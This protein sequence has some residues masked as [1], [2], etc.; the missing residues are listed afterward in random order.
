MGWVVLAVVGIVIFCVA[1]VVHKA[2]HCPKCKSRKFRYFGS[3]NYLCLNCGQ[4][5][6][7]EDDV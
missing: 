1:F 4:V 2:I 7:V 6:N 3:G 5:V